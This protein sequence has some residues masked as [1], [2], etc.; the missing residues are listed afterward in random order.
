MARCMR[1]HILRCFPQAAAGS[2]FAPAEDF[3]G[4]RLPSKSRWRRK[5]DRSGGAGSHRRRRAKVSV[6]ELKVD[7]LSQCW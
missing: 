1:D 2:V 3:V 7:L 5:R 4:P 6:E